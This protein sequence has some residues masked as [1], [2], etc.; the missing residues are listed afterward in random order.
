MKQ[1]LLSNALHGMDEFLNKYTH[2]KFVICF[3]SVLLC[4]I[5]IPLLF[6]VFYFTDTILT[7]VVYFVF[8]L[9]C[10][11]TFVYMTPIK[12]TFFFLECIVCDHFKRYQIYVSLYFCIIW[13]NNHFKLE[14]IFS[15]R[16]N[17]TKAPNKRYNP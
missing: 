1:L 14:V 11:N 13:C 4:T 16:S 7:I 10:L 3:S 6:L 2:H 17:Q 8:Y 15:F 9:T 5:F 12:K